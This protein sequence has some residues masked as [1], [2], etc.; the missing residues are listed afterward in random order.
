MTSRRLLVVLALLLGAVVGLCGADNALADPLNDLVH[1]PRD[2]ALL[3]PTPVPDPWLVPPI[4]FE[5]SPPGTVLGSRPVQV[6]PLLT[7]ATAT[8]LLVRSTDSKGR[9]VPVVTTVI[10]PTAPWNG[11]GPRPVVGYNTAIDSLGLT[12]VPSWTLPRGT[13]IELVGIEAMLA[14]NYAVVVTDHQGPRQAYGAG[15]MSGHAVLDSL[16]AV[17]RSSASG[18]APESPIVLYGYSGGAIA[19]AWAAELAPSYAPEL[20][21][22]G[23]AIGGVPADYRLLLGSMNGTNLA[24]G[25]FLAAVLGVARE[26]PE[27]FELMNDDG[28]RL[29][30]IAKD[31]CLTSLAPPGVVAPIPVQ[32]LSDVPDVLDTPI[33]TRVL[34]DLTLGRQAPTASI[35]LYQGDYDIWLPPAGVRELR[36]AWCAHGGTVHLVE[37]PGEHV[38]VGLAGMPAAFS[39]LE[40]RVAGRPAPSDCA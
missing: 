20:N 40:D 7:P 30:T 23:A 18:V 27:L 8:Q 10:V 2:P 33:V 17:T 25:V 11:P 3:Y 19:A 15:R 28:W 22:V 32:A 34:D 35:L 16:R 29:G 37:Y 1:P 31:W 13:E 24:S 5:Q 9:P 38:G 26:Y 12:C 6:G 21:V 4:G 14:R 36:D 39:W